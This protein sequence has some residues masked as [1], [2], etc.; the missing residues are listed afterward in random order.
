MARFRWTIKRKLL[1]LGAGT[2]LPLVLLLAFWVWWEVKHKTEEAES[3]LA[4]ASA[5]AAAQVEALVRREIEHLERLVRSAAVRRR[6]VARMEELFREDAEHMQAEN[7]LAVAVD[8][9]TFTS[10]VAQ[11]R[12]APATAADRS[13]FR[14][15]MATGRPAVGGFE[16]G[17]ITGLPVAVVAVPLGEGDGAPAG[18]LGAALSLRRL[19]ALFRALPL[20]SGMTVTVLDGE[21]H[22]LS[23]HPL[24]TEPRIGT[25][26]PATSAL[27]SGPGKVARLPW[28]E[29]GER[30]AAV[31]P[32]AGTGWTVLVATPHAALEGGVWT[33]VRSVGLPLI[34]LLAASGIVGLLIARRVWRP[35]EALTAAVARLPRG[36]R[37]TISADSSDEAGQLGQ[38]FN[39]MAVQVEESRSRLERQ[40]SELT[41]LTEAGHLLT[42][43]LER[44]EVLQRLTELLRAQL[45]VDI[46]RVWL[47]EPS[48]GGFRLDAHAGFEQGQREYRARLEPG[49]G[50]IGW[51]MDHREP[52]VL[53]DVQSDPRLRNREWAEAERLRSFLGVPIFLGDVPIGILACLTRERRVF[54]AADV[55]VVQLLAQPAA[56]A[57]L[58]A[59]LYEEAR[60]RARQVEILHETARAIVAE[61][62]LDRLL[63]RIADSA[64][65][66][67]G[68]RYGALAVFREDGKIRQFF[69]AGLTPEKSARA[70]P[71]PQGRGLLGYVFQ[72]HQTVRLDDLTK[73]PAFSGF[74]PGHPSMRSLLAVPLRLRGE[75]IGAL[76]LAEKPGGFTAE[77]ETLLTALGADAGVA[78]DN[79]RLLGSLR[80]TLDNLRSKEEQLVQGEAL[81]AVGNLASGIAH[82]LNN[83]FAVVQ[84]RARLLLRAAADPAL[85]RGLETVERAAVEGVDVVRRLQSFSAVRPASGMVP[86][87]LNEIAR[88]VVELTRPRWQDEA[89]AQGITIEVKL[90]RD[91][92]PL[93]IGSRAAIS[94]VLV[95][96]VLN[97]IEA[98]SAQGLMIVRTWAAAERVHCSVSDT[99]A[100]MSE[101]VRR[102]A[103]EPFFTSKGPKSRGLGLSVSYGIVQR[104]GGTL[105][106][107]SQ[108][109]RGTTVTISLPISPAAVAAAPP[110]AQPAPPSSVSPRRIL[111][112]DD[113]ADVRE[114]TADL[115]ATE[116]HLVTQAASGAE[117]VSMFRTHRYDVVFTDLGMPGMT[118][119]E[120]AEAIKALDAATPVVLLTGWADEIDEAARSH[121]CVDQIAGKPLDL[122]AVAPLIATAPVRRHG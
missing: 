41:A 121:A 72:Q 62:D 37:I 54:S 31:T 104:H 39:A 94:E 8:G 3:T 46:V 86:V 118:G 73:H 76:Y 109:G 50:L 70:G 61:R 84:G 67:I 74:P 21:G 80:E 22:V 12:G 111:V 38:A 44:A 1:A 108:P 120:V 51:I 33:E 35:L 14:Q 18:A 90:E 55:A 122:V 58:N 63:Q 17:R 112:I 114:T 103:L 87:D 45:S 93:V 26:L 36:E 6:D 60:A 91:K 4:L 48:S 9:R 10:A 13:W 19:D 5:Q 92:I 116:G 117:G 29:G 64:R 11:P 69:A 30:L 89:R 83:I 100:G 85:R 98:V 25:R 49:E 71:P 32:V 107:E 106:I 105:D 23:H 102:Q 42:G 119:W 34:A 82:H 53:E 65:E 88:E 95:N 28:F 110:R 56:V 97:A 52:V 24:N 81:R 79:A 75:T 7:V 77:D 96:L 66:L 57:I 16:I 59:R 43:T 27:P 40:I 47:W 68:A 99:G 113:D 101:E 2:F 78:I 15:V 20:G 115:L